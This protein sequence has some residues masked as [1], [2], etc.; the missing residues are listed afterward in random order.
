MDVSKEEKQVK[1]SRLHARIFAMFITSVF[2][3][4]FATSVFAATMY[5]S[6]TSGSKTVGESFSVG[7]YVSTPDEAMNAVSGSLSFSTEQLEA[8]SVTTGG[9]I[10]GLWVQ[11]PTYSNTTGKVTFEGVVFNP[12]YQGS[13]GNLFTVTFK[14]KSAGSANVSFSSGQVLAN[15]GKGTNILKGL[16]TA[17]YT[18]S[19]AP[20]VTPT[21]T[22]T[23]KSTV[24]TTPK[25]TSTTVPESDD[26]SE[27]VIET[28]PVQESESESAPETVAETV[29][30]EMSDSSSTNISLT[31]LEQRLPPTSLH[32][33]VVLFLLLVSAIV[34]FGLGR[35]FSRHHHYHTTNG[36]T[37]SAAELRAIHKRFEALHSDIR[38]ARP[39]NKTEEQLIKKIRKDIESAEQAVFDH[40][41]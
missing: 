13:A 7:V 10:V 23:Q 40:L 15:D 18:I 33:A 35:F 20:T 26:E 34:L 19:L 30:T 6:P 5:P 14:S 28:E 11:T 17:T 25:P 16:G 2:S 12:G 9:S 8:T 39:L 4:V 32:P 22:V 31:E 41:L 21:T 37:I 24:T 1:M 29:V 3:F 27:P 36:G 38:L